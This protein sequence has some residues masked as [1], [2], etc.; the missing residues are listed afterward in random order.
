MTTYIFPNDTS[1]ET[2]DFL[3]SALSG[4]ANGEES[5]HTTMTLH[6][7]PRVR[8]WDNSSVVGLVSITLFLLVIL[9]FSRLTYL[10]RQTLNYY[11]NKINTLKADTF[12]IEFVPY[13]VCWGVTV[14]SCAFVGSVSVNRI[15]PVQS[16]FQELYSIFFILIGLV[17]GNLLG[18]WGMF[19]VL[20]KMFRSISGLLAEYQRIY[21][22]IIQLMGLSL[23][24]V[25]LAIIYMPF[26]TVVLLSIA[27]LC[28]LTGVFMLLYKCIQLFFSEPV[29]LYY[30]I[31]YFCASEI[32]PVLVGLKLLSGG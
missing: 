21:F 7:I 32:L 13:V 22:I 9:C 25:S 23:F 24:I 27:V 1:P 10:Y 5:S 29:S 2:S 3:R 31:L 20:K 26:K 6:A 16:S 11:F 19:Y 18:K 12:S 8:T 4:V 28:M 15:L 30:I 17:T 14:I